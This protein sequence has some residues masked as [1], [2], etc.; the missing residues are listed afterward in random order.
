MKL[1]LPNA[2]HYAFF[3]DIDGT[4]APLAAQPED[5]TIAPEVRENLERLAARCEG[6]LALVSGRTIQQLDA[7]V[8][9][10]TLPLAAVHG[11][12]CRNLQG[13][14][15]RNALPADTAASLTAELERAVDLLAG[16]RLENKGMA[17]ALHY[18]QAPWHQRTIE[19]LAQSLASRFPELVVQPGKC[20]VELKPRTVN[21]GA[22]IETLMQQPPFAGR[23]PVFLGDD[24]TDEAGFQRVNAMKGISV[25]VGE[26]KSV[27]QQRLTDVDAVH[28]W[29]AQLLTGSSL[30]D[31]A[32]LR[33]HN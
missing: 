13:E 6:A 10:L 23:T 8:A 16:S 33:S 18:R 29:L 11:A 32:A 7:L 5:V 22:A 19:Q 4:L 3:F 20:V 25:K 17:F 27:A 14:I 9:P 12:E 21:K 28:R 26:G 2:A 15:T 1:S 24:D 30:Q 31:A